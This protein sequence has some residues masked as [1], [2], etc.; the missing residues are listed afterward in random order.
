[1]IG[2]KS[3][4]TGKEQD[5]KDGKEKSCPSHFSSKRLRVANIEKTITCEEN[6]LAGFGY[7]LYYFGT[8]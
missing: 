2:A 3:L 5:G 4:A 8:K 1:M 6:P 7:L